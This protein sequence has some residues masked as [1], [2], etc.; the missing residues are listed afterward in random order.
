M[1]TILADNNFKCIFLNENDRI[2][3]NFPKICSQES[4][5]QYASISSGDGLALNKRQA[6]TWT[7]ADPVHWCIYA[8][9]GEDELMVEMWSTDSML[10]GNHRVW[11]V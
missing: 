3:L 6:I 11:K 4:N 10:T 7:N 5:W 2:L 1:A 9:L 8:A